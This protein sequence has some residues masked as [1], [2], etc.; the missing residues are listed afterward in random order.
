[1]SYYNL[2]ACCAKK[3][4]RP[5]EARDLYCSQWF[6]LARTIVE[7]RGERWGILSAQYNFLLPD[8]WVRPYDKR[9]SS[10]T[11]E[12]K[13]AWA[14]TICNV[15]PPLQD[16]ERGY[17]IWGGVDYAVP[18]AE[19]LD[20][21]LP[22]EHLG[23]GQ[24]LSYM[25]KLANPAPPL[26]DASRAALDL[27]VRCDADLLPGDMEPASDWDWDTARFQLQKAVA[28]AA[29]SSMRQAA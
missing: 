15:L 9:M 28:A 24:Q 10:L 27:L 29:A 5:A 21:Y 25:S 3:L 19:M 1:M 17:V 11:R 22:L 26:L 4:S 23:I 2:I 18:L 12:E 14:E 7:Q 16:N 6:R 13:T 20:A 8:S